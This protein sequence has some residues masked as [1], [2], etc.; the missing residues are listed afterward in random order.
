MKNVISILLLLALVISC[1]QTPQYTINGTLEGSSEELIYLQKRGDGEFI[2]IDSALVTE[3]MFT[4]TGVV[5]IPEMYY[6][7]IEGKRGSA[8][9]WIENSEITLTAHADTL[10]QAEITGSAVQDEYTA[11]QDELSE[12]YEQSRELYQKYR[13]AK[14]NG[15]EES[16][17]KLEEMMDSIS[18]SADQF[19]KDWIKKNPSSYIAP[20]ALQRIS[21]GMEA[22][23]IE[24][25]LGLLDPS[26]A[27]TAIVTDLKERIEI[28]KKV[29]IGQPAI[30]F[31]QNDTEGNPVTL[32]SLYGNY[33]LVD[34][35]A[36]WC[37]PCRQENPNVVACYEEFHD[38]GF[39]II[40][41][42]LDRTEED[43]LKAIED[44]GLTWTQVSD[45]K[46]W[47]NEVSDMYGINSI[48]SSLLLDK[49]GIII[50]KS[51]RGDDLKNKLAE[52]MPE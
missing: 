2:K 50:G 52:L 38:K 5:E 14:Q 4:F 36:A 22:D 49:E 34:F 33:I 13:E 37:G 16:M 45:L 39:E 28:L 1:S 21:Y 51:L 41:V 30:D 12:I 24:E 47:G 27:N 3:G 15:E 25:Y 40:G 20:S 10:Y 11:F 32:S 46:G 23:E 7:S 35:W 31:T 9:I 19:Q 42:S 18:D 29:A 17:K 6:L 43:W 8:A 44:D 26:L 48:P